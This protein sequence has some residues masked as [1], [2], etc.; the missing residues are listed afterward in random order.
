M[1]RHNCIYWHFDLPSV[2]NAGSASASLIFAYSGREDTSKAGLLPASS[3]T[4]DA[5]LQIVRERN[6]GALS[7]L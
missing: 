3:P 7:Y 1:I 6:V 5:K 2:M 4:P